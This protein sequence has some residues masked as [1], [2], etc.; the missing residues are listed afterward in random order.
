VF[1][2]FLRRGKERGAEAKW[3]K[4]LTRENSLSVSLHQ[5]PWA[6]QYQERQ[7]TKPTPRNKPVSQQTKNQITERQRGCSLK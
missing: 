2:F 6:T 1:C 7:A 4:K 3:N 5:A